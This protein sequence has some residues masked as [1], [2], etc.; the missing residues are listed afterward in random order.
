MGHTGTL[1][2]SATG[3]MV[4]L[5]GRATKLSAALTNAD[6]E[7]EGQFTLGEETDTQDADGEMVCV[8]PFEHVT[9]G[10][11]EDE[12][13]RWIGVCS[14]M[15]PMFSAKKFHGVP[16]Y[17][18]ARKGKTVERKMQ[19][20]SITSFQLLDYEAPMVRFRLH[21]SKGTYVRTLVNDVGQNL[22]CGAHLTDL[23]RTLNGD[24]DVH[25]A[26]TLDVLLAMPVEEVLARVIPRRP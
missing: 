21:C 18:L 10:K 3:L 6:K 23:R 25:D 22:G 9:R 17:K 12:M 26:L 20:I 15:P 13:A 16:M 7:Y 1:D 2:P 24:F 19:T 4:I 11:L 14:Q 5:V 8:R